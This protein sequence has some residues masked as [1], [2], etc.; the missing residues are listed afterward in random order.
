MKGMSRDPPGKAGNVSRNVIKVT[1]FPL[2]A[3]EESPHSNREFPK[4]APPLAPAWPSW[5]ILD[6]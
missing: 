3:P 2:S 1:C 6:C 5:I 4:V